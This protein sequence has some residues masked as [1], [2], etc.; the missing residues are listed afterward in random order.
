MQVLRSY[1]TIIFTRTS[2]DFV[3]VVVLQTLEV[4][5][6]SIFLLLEHDLKFATRMLI[7]DV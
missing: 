3:T 2:K 5:L 4:S 1:D 7:F 6:I